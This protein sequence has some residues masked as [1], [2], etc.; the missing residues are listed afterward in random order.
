L[1]NHTLSTFPNLDASYAAGSVR[2]CHSKVSFTLDA[3][4]YVAFA[5]GATHWGHP[6]SEQKWKVIASSN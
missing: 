6:V 1:V 3:V 4:C 5:C 2:I